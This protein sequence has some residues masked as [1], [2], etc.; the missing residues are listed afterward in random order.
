M[1][2]KEIRIDAQLMTGL[3]IEEVTGFMWI[4]D[5]IK[6]I[7]R[8]HPESAP[9]KTVEFESQGTMEDGDVYEFDSELIRL[10]KVTRHNSRRVINQ[11]YYECENDKITF[12]HKGDFDITYRYM[13]AAPQTVDDTIP[14]PDRYAELIK[15]Y[16]ASRIRA[17][18]YG[19]GD[20]DAQTYDQLFWSHL[21]DVDATMEAAVRRYRIIPVRI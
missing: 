4:K 18:I 11:P 1:T 13:P 5:A 3:Q 21:S 7:V 6:Y 10:E 8:N 20:P 16:V 9:K 15:Y 14:I 17:R 2:S 19:Q 12:Y